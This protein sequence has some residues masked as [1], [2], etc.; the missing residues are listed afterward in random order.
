M[1]SSDLFAE[2]VQM[3]LESSR[4]WLGELMEAISSKD[5]DGVTTA[6]HG[7]QSGSGIVGASAL[8]ELCR[9]LE[10]LA[11]QADLSSALQLQ[12]KILAEHRLVVEALQN[13]GE[14][15]TGASTPATESA[16]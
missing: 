5:V 6:A 9:T 1:T 10:N 11:R 16:E 12:E 13:H 8:I 15:E 7:L 3:Y 14:S 4:K 2:V